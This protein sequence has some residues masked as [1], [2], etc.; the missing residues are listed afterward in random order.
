MRG[1]GGLLQLC[2]YRGRLRRWI[3][4]PTGFAL[5]LHLILSAAVIGHFAASKA[6]ATGDLFVICHGAGD[7]SPADP[8]VPLQQPGYQSHCVL[9]ALTNDACALIPTVTAIAAFEAGALSQH[10]IPRDS[11]VVQFVSLVS[12]Y[13]RGPPTHAHVAG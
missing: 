9:C 7:N 11:Q 6:G 12:E 10:T 1:E 4:A 3:A 5:A 8:D 2:R 13:P